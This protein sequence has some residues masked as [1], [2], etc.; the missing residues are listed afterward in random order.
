MRQCGLYMVRHPRG[1]GRT[2]LHIRDQLR[3]RVTAA[4]EMRGMRMPP[5]SSNQLPISDR[6]SRAEKSQIPVFVPAR[7][8]R[9]VDIVF[10]NP[11]VSAKAPSLLRTS[12]RAAVHQFEVKFWQSPPIRPS[13]SR[14][15]RNVGKLPPET[16]SASF[17]GAPAHATLAPVIG[18]CSGG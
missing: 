10:Q 12:N 8:R 16:D 11:P 1:A 3:F 15:V 13:P 4:E 5:P 7:L 14:R 17:V 6:H 18:P 9:R 2:R